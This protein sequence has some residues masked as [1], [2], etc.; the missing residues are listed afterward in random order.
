VC[1]GYDASRRVFLKIQQEY[2]DVPE[3][4]TLVHLVRNI[5]VKNQLPALFMKVITVDR[6]T[7]A[8]QFIITMKPFRPFGIVVL[9]VGSV[10]VGWHPLVSTLRLAV[11]NDAYT[12]I[13]LILPLSLTFIYAERKSL[14]LAAEPSVYHGLVVLCIAAVTAALSQWKTIGMTADVQVSIIM[15]AL[16]TWWIGSFVFCFGARVSRLMLFPLCFLFWMVPLPAFV[17]NGIIKCLQ[18]GSVLATRLLF[19]VFSVPVAQDGVTLSIPGLTVEVTKQCSSIRSS[20]ML[21]VTTMVLAQLLLR[22][23]WRRLL[24]IT[25]AVPLSVAKNG[26]RIFTLAMLGTRVDPGFLTGRLHH[27]GGIVFFSIALAAVFLLLGVLRGAEAGV[28][29]AAVLRSASPETVTMVSG[30]WQK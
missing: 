16:V 2:P 30:V 6:I 8:W 20:M 29:R 24:V 23:P 17:L 19:G 1:S 10:V 27:D 21:L 25:L 7:A 12:H 13:L 15:L 5:R 11:E 14:H 4:K 9:L 28:T 22:S 26:I 3:P 18:Q